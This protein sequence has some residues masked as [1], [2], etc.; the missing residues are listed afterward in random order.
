M[1]I[2]VILTFLGLVGGGV[3]VWVKLNREIG[4]MSTKLI[5]LET[6]F[7]EHRSRSETSVDSLRKEVNEKIDR[8]A[9]EMHNL[10]YNIAK[11][12]GKIEAQEERQ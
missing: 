9:E 10:N 7:A 1:E 4:V 6:Q 3:A 12:I 8:L 11:L 5:N 2:S